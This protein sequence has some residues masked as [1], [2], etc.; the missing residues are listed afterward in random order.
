[1][2]IQD[3]SM[4]NLLGRN[5]ACTIRRD[6]QGVWNSFRAWLWFPL[7]LSLCAAFLGVMFTCVD[8]RAFMISS[9]MSFSRDGT[10]LYQ[11]EVTAL[12]SATLVVIRLIADVC[13]ALLAWRLIVAL[14]E[15]AGVTLEELCR[16]VDSRMPIMPRWYSVRQMFWSFFAIIVIVLMWPSSVAAP[17][18]NSSIQ[19][20]PST[21]IIPSQVQDLAPPRIEPKND[22]PAL[23]YPETIQ[24]ITLKAATM[25]I[26][27]PDFTGAFNRSSQGSPRRFLYL[28]PQF[29]QGGLGNMTMPFFEAVDIAW[30]PWPS[31][32]RT[33]DPLRNGSMMENP[34]LARRAGSLGFLQPR[35]WRFQDSAEYKAVAY[36]GKKT[37][38]VLVG[39]IGTDQGTE[40]S[41]C[42]N[43]STI[44]GVLPTV[45]QLRIAWY[46]NDRWAA[47]DCWL[48]AEVSFTAGK[49][50]QQACDIT[51]IGAA[52][53]MHIAVPTN[54]SLV[55]ELDI[56]PD[57]AVLP[58]LDL[59]TDVLRNLVLMNV[60]GAFRYNNLEGY[61]Q[62]ILSAAYYSTHSALLYQL[63]SSNET[64]S[65]V[66][67]ESVIRASINRPRLYGWLALN[68]CLLI[69]ALMLWIVWRIT[70]VTSKV[71]QMPT[72]VALT[73]DLNA[74]SHFNGDGL[75]NAVALKS[76]DKKLGRMVWD[77]DSSIHCRKVRFATES[78][79]RENLS[80][81]TLYIPLK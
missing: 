61:I 22:W 60:G 33:S 38:P 70:R 47:Y 45:H 14:L 66:Q 65:A 9:T 80:A 46:F 69:A 71:V 64:A 51:L 11:A 20:I 5:R 40:D 55:A 18:A 4:E 34:P 67:M 3:T 16:I 39:S 30:V 58:T 24:E 78:K 26:R 6:D 41:Q 31:E 28:N 73:M 77:K 68:S 19:W 35:Q 50:D 48:L 57:L 1:M 2:A 56:K 59:M 21:R 81:S 32:L 12:V 53:D 8:G 10:G 29:P 17:L 42:P 74:V 37:I 49:A 75:C 36:K 76:K 52:D 44:F 23:N 72:L 43:T 62:G 13:S 54:S 27:S 63:K 7:H 25:G 79:A 15:K